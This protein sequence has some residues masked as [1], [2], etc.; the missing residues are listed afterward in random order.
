[1]DDVQR[2]RR[3]Y[4]DRTL[5]LVIFALGGLL[6]YAVSSFEGADSVVPIGLLT[7]L[8]AAGFYVPRRLAER[9]RRTRR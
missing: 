3:I 2:N 8:V 7:A 4:K 5:V 9:R 6:G 1:M